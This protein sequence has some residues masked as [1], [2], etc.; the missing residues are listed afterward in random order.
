MNELP[1]VMLL[2]KVNLSVRCSS[3]PMPLLYVHHSYLFY[4]Q[5]SSV[6]DISLLE[7]KVALRLKGFYRHL[8]TALL[9]K[10][11]RYFSKICIYLIISEIVFVC[12][13]VTDHIR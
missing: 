8:S 3:G 9:V 10:F 5:E 7:I 12:L 1:T 6:S 2:S 13:S 11:V 4:L